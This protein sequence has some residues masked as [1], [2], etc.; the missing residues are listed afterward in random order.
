MTAL[1]EGF[2]E[3][4]LSEPGELPPRPLPS[5]LLPTL[6]V[7]VTE[8]RLLV[9]IAALWIVAQRLHVEESTSLM[10]V[11]RSFAQLRRGRAERLLRIDMQTRYD[12]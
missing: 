7:N 5:C 8:D 12:V 11:A 6:I 10:C 2:R 3:P 9:V 4:L 1:I